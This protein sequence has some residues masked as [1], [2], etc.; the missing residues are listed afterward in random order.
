MKGAIISK[1]CHNT[2][3]F[4]EVIAVNKKINVNG[5]A[6]DTYGAKRKTSYEG[7][8]NVFILEGSKKFINDDFKVQSRILLNPSTQCL[9]G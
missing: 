1:P 2:M 4:I 3:D 5:C 8:A 7:I 6:R 9:L